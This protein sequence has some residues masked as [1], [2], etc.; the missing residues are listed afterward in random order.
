MD[1][2][3]R[4]IALTD[5]LLHDH[6]DDPPRDF[7]GAQFDM[8]LAFVHFPVG[9]GGLG[10]SPK[11]QL[12]INR[13]I[14]DAGVALVRGSIG[15]GMGAPTIVVHGTEEQKR[16]FLRPL[17]T[18]EE[19]WCQLFSE[20]GAGSDVAS[21]ATTAVRDGDEWVVNGQK[22]WTSLAHFS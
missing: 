18:N 22:V 3:A 5:Q 16:R 21:L 1:D 11:L 12:V 10:L 13:R 7:Y 8:G 17:F 6:S 2:E 4:V 19:V 14:T 15:H 20:P 9:H